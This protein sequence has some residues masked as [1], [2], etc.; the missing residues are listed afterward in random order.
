MPDLASLIQESGMFVDL[1]EAVDFLAT[2]G[3]GFAGY[4]LGA[5]GQEPTDR[6]L[7]ASVRRG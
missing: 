1:R 6:D 2:E 5:T 4:T 7:V 3:V